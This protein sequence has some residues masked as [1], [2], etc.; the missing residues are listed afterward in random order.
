MT[1]DRAIGV[2]L[3]D[4]AL[5]GSER[6]AIRLANAWARLGHRTIVYAG[7]NAGTQ[8]SLVAEDVAVRT[9]PM[10]IERGGRSVR[11]L[12]LWAGEQCRADGV[13]SMFLPGNS[14]YTAVRP[15]LRATQG[16][17]P[18]FAKISNILWRPDRSFLRNRAFGVVTRWRL[19]GVRSMVAM[20]SGLAADARRSLGRNI[21]CAVIASGILDALPPP[22]ESARNEWQIF[23]AGRLEPQKNFS[24]LLKAVAQLGDLPITVKIAGDGSLR[25]Q[26]HREAAAL[27]I[28]DRVTFLG[29]LSDVKPL[30]AQSELVVL[31]SDFEGYPAVAV[32]AL[33]HGAFVIARD[34]SPAIHEILRDR[35]VGVVV[36]EKDPASLASAIR[37]YLGHRKADREAMRAI[38]AT[39][40]VD[41]VARRYIDLFQ[42]HRAPQ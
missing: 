37:S 1:G 6:I 4:F 38:A 29:L 32:E 8:R 2:L 14:Y 31:P 19:G 9:P 17:I 35:E 5:G 27:G 24:L 39:H 30:M 41:S 22:T 18:L 28:E 25:E 3:H 20:S 12:A 34:C 13:T 15:F 16:H 33:A 21:P 23:A 36:A 42:S 26:L 40:L 7:S 11:D 10:P